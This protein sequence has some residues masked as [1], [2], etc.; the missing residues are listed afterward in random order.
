M[1]GIQDHR[2]GNVVGRVRERIL[3]LLRVPV[4]IGSEAVRQFRIESAFFRFPE[5]RLPDT[6]VREQVVPVLVRVQALDTERPEPARR[7]APGDAVAGVDVDAVK[8]GI[9][10]RIV[11]VVGGD[12]HADRT[13]VPVR[14]RF[15]DVR[16]IGAVFP[17][18]EELLVGDPAFLVLDPLPDIPV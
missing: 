1:D 14:R 12:G 4:L 9:R 16:E 15:G 2:R 3:D 5:V 18:G 10:E 6:V 8:I 17:G 7:Q 13:P 11:I